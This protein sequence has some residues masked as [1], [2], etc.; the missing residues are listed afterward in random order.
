MCYSSLSI[1]KSK[2]SQSAK[3]KFNIP[4]MV[5]ELKDV[6]AEED[7]KALGSDTKGDNSGTTAATT[8]EDMQISS[9]A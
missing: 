6:P 3:P 1:E 4:I 9:S 2:F 8:D 5:E 7:P